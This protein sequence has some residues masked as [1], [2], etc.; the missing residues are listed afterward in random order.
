MPDDRGFEYGPVAQEEALALGA[1]LSQALHFNMNEEGV[2]K[3]IER[4]GHEGFRVVRRQGQMAAG[5]G[6][7]EMGQWFGGSRVPVVGLSP[8]GTAA[9]HRGMGA[10]SCL[11]HRMHE[12]VYARGFPLAVL[13]PATVT[14]YRRT[15]YERA[16]VRNTYELP[17]DA[18]D[19]KERALEVVPA[20][21]AD[22]R[23][24]ER[25]VGKECR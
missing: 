19:V 17:T 16:G 18:I 6:I 24:E 20:G 25:R 1:M 7:I 2:R 9:E 21:E 8:V 10:A 23:S 13:F 11:M 14:F 15:G 3:W 4:V 5:L 22:Y 12:E